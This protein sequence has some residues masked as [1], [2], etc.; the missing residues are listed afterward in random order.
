MLLLLKLFDYTFYEMQYTLDLI[1]P[2]S[3]GDCYT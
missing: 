2:N 3:T 1:K